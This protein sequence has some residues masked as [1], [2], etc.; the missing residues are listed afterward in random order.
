VWGTGEVHKGF[1]WGSLEEEGHLKDQI[2]GWTVILKWVFKE[3]DGGH[4]LD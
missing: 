4:E 1:W 3:R 2:I